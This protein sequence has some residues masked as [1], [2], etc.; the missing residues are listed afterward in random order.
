[1]EALQDYSA[2]L[3]WPVI[4]FWTNIV[5]TYSASQIEFVGT[6]LVQL[7]FFWFPSLAYLSLDAVAPAFSQRH[8]IQPAP[9]Q[10]SRRDIIHCFSVVLQNQVLSSVLHLGLINITSRLGGQSAYRIEKSLPTA[11]EFA[12]DFVLS[13][14]M[15]EVMFYYSHRVLHEKPLYKLIHK[16]HHRFTAPVALA[17][18]YAHPV[19]QIFANV[20][21][22]SLPPQLLD[23]HVLT[24][25]C[26]LAF[27]L[28]ETSTVHSGYDFFHRKA[29]MHDLH[30]AKFNLN[31]GSLGLLDWFHQT[32]RLGKQH[33]E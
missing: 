25:W 4:T 23:S 15:R 5:A 14:L 20:L 17:A 28:F 26:F 12:R 29:A 10:P 19:E 18:Q 30:H 7:I 9:R 3:L 16:K 2:Q 32:D 24:F 8:K 31:Y 22:I 21:P 1:M 33:S 13:L 6:L 27:E 11:L